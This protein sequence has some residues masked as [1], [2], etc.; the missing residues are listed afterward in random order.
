MRLTGQE[1][2]QAT[3]GSWRKG[4]PGM[5]EGIGTDSRCFTPGH[6]FL[7]LRGSRFDGHRHAHEVADVASALIGDQQ[8]IHLWEHLEVPQLTV[9]D[10]LKAL[11]DI[12]A[13]WRSKLQHTTVI[14]ISGS[15]GKT[16]LRSMLCQG[17]S[18]LDQSVAATRG[19]L[20]NLIGVPMT[21]LSVPP[22]CDIAIVECGISEPGEMQRLGRTVTPDIAILTRLGSGHAAG[23]GGIRGIAAEKATLLEF[24]RPGGLAILGEGVQQIIAPEIQKLP[25]KVIS[26]DHPE[27]SISWELHDGRVML[28]N[29]HETASI[30]L[31]L[32]ARHLAANLALAACVI[33][34]CLERKQKSGIS[35]ESI[36]AA[37]SGWEPEP[38]RL[39]S[40]EGKGGCLILDDSYNA[41]PES[42]QAAL[43]TLAA[44]DGRKIAILG[45]MAELG[46][47]SE[48]MHRGIDLSEIDVA[49]LI[50]PNMRQLAKSQPQAQ[51]FESVSAAKAFIVR[52]PCDAKDRILLKAS[53]SMR[54]ETL[55]P[56][57]CAEEEGHA[58]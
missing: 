52:M 39:H 45:D 31:S 4:M 36:A 12:A 27:Q 15:C 53:R 24:I 2:L 33:Q 44:M 14:A 34:A 54:L 18:R 19:N 56:A 35:L 28:R 7:A 42:M 48:A 41:N 43:D 3:G 11:G 50:G 49:I 8:G 23:L 25:C 51:W 46:E 38:G 57:L 5:V 10:T 9:A 30:R 13:Y 37:L 26:Q 6:A 22:D 17:F 32:P 55:I 21:L 29:S 40:F 58:V 16:T 47:L 1:L 20:N